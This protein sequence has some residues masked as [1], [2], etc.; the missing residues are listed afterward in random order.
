MELD[1]KYGNIEGIII[2]KAL[3]TGSMDLK[4]AIKIARDN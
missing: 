3:Y 2:G 4:D 1:K